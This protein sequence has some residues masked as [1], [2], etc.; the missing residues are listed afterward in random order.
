MGAVPEGGTAP[1]VKRLLDVYRVLLTGIH[2]M[3]AG[4]VKANLAVL[5]D[6]FRLPYIW[7]LI[8]PNHR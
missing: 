1:R 4:I 5:N 3:R 6:E 8:D 2:L 7:E